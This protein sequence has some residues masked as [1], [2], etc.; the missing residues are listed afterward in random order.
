VRQT[1][2]IF[3]EYS[4][5]RD[6][7][8][9]AKAALNVLRYHIEVLSK[10]DREAL[11]AMLRTR[12]EA[13]KMPAPAS[14]STPATD[15]ASESPMSTAT[16]PRPQK[17][18]PIK[19]IGPTNIPESTA[20][21]PPANSSGNASQPA[22]TITP[23]VPDFAPPSS[24]AEGDDVVWVNCLHCG[25]TNQRHEVFCYSCGQLLEPVKG[26]GDTRVLSEPTSNP[27]DSEHFGDDSVLV[28]RVRGSAENFEV[29]PQKSD[30][31]MIIG[32]STKGS[33][34]APDIDLTN[35]QASDLGV[36]RLH[37]SIRHDAEHSALLVADLGSANGSYLN[38]QRMMP[39]EV[40]VLR[41]GDELRLGK[42]V[43]L[44]SFRH[45][46]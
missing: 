45:P 23:A 3:A 5:M 1:K 31:E 33:V 41:H 36:S 27:L 15:A 28:L 35:K 14:P 8:L 44:A 40:R 2:E 7:G 26:V 39:K 11:A 43:L 12:E 42:L 6:N 19:P 13:A 34:L 32:R 37:L 16:A 38:G 9:D 20:A 18:N 29:R 25:K 30:H 46:A 17:I 22:V 24:G 21:S 4:R 10:A